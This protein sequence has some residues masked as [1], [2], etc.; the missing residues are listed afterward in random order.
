MMLE[1]LTKKRS[2]K[3]KKNKIFPECQDMALGEEALPRVLGRGTR[4]RFFNCN[5]TGGLSRQ[6][7]NF[8]PECHSSPSVAL[9]EER[10]PRVPTFPEC[11]A[12]HGTRE[13]LSFPSAFL[14]RVHSSLALGEE[15]AGEVTLALGFAAGGRPPSRRA[16]AV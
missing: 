5:G 6:V 12:P 14:P 2:K 3:N 1:G 15:W 7:A 10:L 11:Q 9:G 4:G 8:F 13:S 16:G